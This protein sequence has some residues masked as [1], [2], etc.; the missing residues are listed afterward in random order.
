MCARALITLYRVSGQEIPGISLQPLTYSDDLE[1]TAN[2]DASKPTISG[3]THVVT[4]RDLEKMEKDNS[5][6]E[7]V[8]LRREKREKDL[9]LL[10]AENKTSEM[11]EASRSTHKISFEDLTAIFTAEIMALSSPPSLAGTFVSQSLDFTVKV[12][13]ILVD[14]DI[15]DIDLWE[16]TYLTPY[17]EN[18]LSSDQSKQVA[19]RVLEKCCKLLGKDNGDDDDDDG[20][21]YL[22]NC[23]F[24][25]GYGAMVLL[26]KARL[27]LKRGARYGICGANGCGITFIT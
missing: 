24:S 2:Y 3:L 1:E 9:E 7:T 26:R 10:I 27:K 6:M 21:N 15:L 22:T 25:L 8:K 14:D 19:R 20:V 18:F 11:L 4:K 23:E 16:D 5:R 13:E 12:A 17:L